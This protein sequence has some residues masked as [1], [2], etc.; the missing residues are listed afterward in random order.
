M[1]PSK[2][3]ESVGAKDSERLAR[4]KHLDIAIPCWWRTLQELLSSH[5]RRSLPGRASERRAERSDDSTRPD[6]RE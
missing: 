3:S 6:V 5:G 1:N 2:D 4:Q